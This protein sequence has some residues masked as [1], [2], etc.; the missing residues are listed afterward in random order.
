MVDPRSSKTHVAVEY[1]H[2]WYQEHPSTK[3]HWVDA[4]SA[5]FFEN[6]FKR[7]AQNLHLHPYTVTGERRT[8]AVV[9]YVHDHLKLD[10]THWLMV[11]DGLDNEDDLKATDP[12][13][14]DK[15]LLDFIP[16]AY[17]ARILFTTRSKSLARTLVGTQTKYVVNINPIKDDD[18]CFLLLGKPT[19]DASK[20]KLINSLASHLDGSAGAM[21]MVLAYWKVKGQGANLKEYKQWLSD[22]SPS[23]GKSVDIVWKLQHELLVSNHQRS[24]D[25]MLQ[26]CALDVQTVPRALFDRGEANEHVPILE[27]YGIVEPSK[28]RPI[29]RVTPLF[30]KCARTWL[31][32]DTEKKSSTE[33]ML[34][35]AV[36]DRFGNHAQ[37][38]MLPCA[39]SVLNFKPS[40]TR[41]KRVTAD[42]HLKV[43]AYYVEVRQLKKAKKHAEECLKLRQA[44]PDSEKK[45]ASVKDAEDVMANI[46]ARITQAKG[47][48]PKKGASR[49]LQDVEEQLQALQKTDEAWKNRE[50]VRQVSHLAA[51]KLNHGQQD[52]SNNSVALYKRILNWAKK[53]AD[54]LERVRHQYNV[55]LA[56]DAAGNDDEAQKHYESAIQIIEKQ[57]ESLEFLSL[58]L[59]I[60][61]CLAC[62]FCAQDQFDKAEDIFKV[63]FPTQKTVLGMDHPDTLVTR[64]NIALLRQERGA[65]LDQV[66]TELQRVLIKQV[67]TL[68]PSDP[69]ILRTARSLGMNWKLA[70]RH[71]EARAVFDGV[72]REQK[73]N[74]GP[75]HRDTRSTKMLLEQLPRVSASV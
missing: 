5:E 11:I 45:A 21:S 68:E 50:T 65:D 20:M 22:S 6:S 52:G 42:L 13:F 51:R 18:A 2:K 10:H 26:L 40:S 1:A 54:P 32:S 64:H 34:I 39:L 16:D 47:E 58:Y 60:N 35:A 43:S 19:K 63:T 49:G 67:H 12:D 25:F 75:D 55:A 8:T 33:E 15:S 31:A 23:R 70:G 73:K 4:S 48:K 66:A 69:E 17:A 29:L 72:L 41:A 36:C 59:K 61:G 14:K 71:E 30:R 57:P 38:S 56:E 9:Q 53:D 74:L 24:E 37:E 28:D 27:E 3:V 7:I 62:L 44:E 46:K